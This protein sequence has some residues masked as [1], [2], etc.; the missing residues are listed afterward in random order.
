MMVVLSHTF[1]AIL[2]VLWSI[3]QTRNVAFLATSVDGD[4]HDFFI[5]WLFILLFNLLALSI[6][7][8]I[9][10][11][12]ITS[13][14]IYFHSFMTFSC[15]HIFFNLVLL[16]I[17]VFCFFEDIAWVVSSYK[18]EDNRDGMHN[19]LL[20]K[21]EITHVVNQVVVSHQRK[22]VKD[23]CDKIEESGTIH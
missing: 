14:L 12:N 5:L 11:H 6:L 16:G 9:Y 21:P 13:L 20:I 4:Y 15:F 8:I 3:G 2:T 22:I 10:L 23:V 18:E 1:I 19:K 7:F 17:T